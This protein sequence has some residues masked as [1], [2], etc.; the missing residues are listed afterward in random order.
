[1]EANYGVISLVPV[2]VVIITAIISKRA[3]EPLI[4]GSIVGFII[5][6][7][8]KFVPAYLGATYTTIGE[9]AYFII[10]FGLF[11]IFIRLLED[12]NAISGFTKLSLK[13]ANTKKKSG[14]LTW[15]MGNIFFLDNYFSILGAAISNKNC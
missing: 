5:L 12:A 3:L 6:D 15:I 10:I 11:G 8:Y 14:L 7:G 2:A 13:F 9:N 4:L 1:M